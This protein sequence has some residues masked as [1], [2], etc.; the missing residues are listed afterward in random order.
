LSVFR[1]RTV[2][3]D[4]LLR[5]IERRHVRTIGSEL[6][7]RGAVRVEIPLSD[8]AV[9]LDY[10]FD[11]LC[12]WCYASA[13]ALE[14]LAEAFPDALT[15]LPSGL[16]AGAGARPVA[17]IAEHAWRNDTRIAELTGQVFATQYRDQ[18]L[19]DP[20]GVFDSISATRAIVAL[21]EVDPSLEPA[22]LQA[23]QSARYVGAKDTANAAVVATVAAKVLEGRGHS[24][25]EDALAD[26]FACDEGLATRTEQRIRTTLARMRE[27]SSSAVPQLLATIGDHREVI[28]GGDLYGGA[29]TVLKAVRAAQN[30]ALSI[31]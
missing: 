12:G 23:L 6:T 17:A 4:R 30:R 25:D 7:S 2:K 29:D 31:H 1:I 22:L 8:R 14:A 9:K 3:I 10:F 13:P 19:G 26:I 5:S 18:V 15:M 21:G 11:P 24:V 20:R 16:F 27:L 28:Q